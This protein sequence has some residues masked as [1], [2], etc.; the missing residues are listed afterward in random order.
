MVFGMSL[1]HLQYKMY[2]SIALSCY[3]RCWMGSQAIFALEMAM[4]PLRPMHFFLS[5]P[6]FA[7][8]ATQVLNAFQEVPMRSVEVRCQGVPSSLEG[9][10]FPQDFA[11]FQVIQAWIFLEYLSQPS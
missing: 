2:K 10:Q 9:K 7:C 4:P 6:A 5:S 11:I 8:V 1:V 3:G